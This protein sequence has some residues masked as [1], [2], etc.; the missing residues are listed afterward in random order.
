M[1]EHE[2]HKLLKFF[3]PS[4]PF[5]SDEEALSRI[6]RSERLLSEIYESNS[7]LHN[8]FEL[9]EKFSR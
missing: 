2:L 5:L 4:H 7:G 3:D 8:H 9:L 1:I 6:D